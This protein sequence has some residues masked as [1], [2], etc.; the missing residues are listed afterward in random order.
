MSKKSVELA[1]NKRQKILSEI[2]QKQTVV[3]T[4]QLHHILN[5]R[6]ENNKISVSR[7]ETVTEGPKK[8]TKKTV[9]TSKKTNM[10]KIAGKIKAKPVQPKKKTSKNY[11]NK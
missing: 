5:Y 1:S 11:T 6:Q 2:K 8:T 9:S 10:T 3:E 7:L 4:I